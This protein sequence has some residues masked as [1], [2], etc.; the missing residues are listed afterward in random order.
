MDVHS[1]LRNKGA[2]LLANQLSGVL[3]RSF[4]LITS[5][6]GGVELRKLA[7]QAEALTTT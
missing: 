5:W 3:K 6:A 2:R 7:E 4:P 1:H